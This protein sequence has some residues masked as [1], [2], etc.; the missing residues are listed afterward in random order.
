MFHIQTVQEL[1]Q[2]EISWGKENLALV[3]QF[4]GQYML[5]G[6]ELRNVVTGGGRGKAGAG[7]VVVE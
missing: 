1:K 3:Q 2:H 5:V 6:V 7:L 4:W